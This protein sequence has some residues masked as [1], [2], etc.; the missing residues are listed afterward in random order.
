M[1]FCT[2]P[3]G[4]RNSLAINGPFKRKNKIKI[5]FN[6]RRFNWDFK[7]HCMH[8]FDFRHTSCFNLVMKNIYDNLPMHFI[9][10][11]IWEELIERTVGWDF[12]NAWQEDQWEAYYKEKMANEYY[13][14]QME[15]YYKENYEDQI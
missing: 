9:N 3:N 6:N 2:I 12:F 15:R 1:I 5:K 11:L 14:E 8:D 4:R 13:Q 10:N 7:D